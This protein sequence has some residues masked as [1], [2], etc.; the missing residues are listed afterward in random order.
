MSVSQ[1]PTIDTQKKFWEWHWQH[2]HDRKTINEW[3]DKRHERI[4]HYVSS[5]RLTRP[6]ILDVGCGPGWY[7]NQLCQFGSVMGIDLSEEAIG[8]AKAAFPHIAFA[9]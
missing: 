2:W 9:A 5:L 3:K 8:M 4:I 7:T 1:Q 6:R